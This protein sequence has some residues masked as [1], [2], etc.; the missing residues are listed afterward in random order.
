[1]FFWF[2]HSERPSECE[3][4]VCKCSRGRKYQVDLENNRH[5]LVYCQYCGSHAIHLGC[6]AGEEFLCDECTSIV[7]R[8]RKNAASSLSTGSGREILRGGN[9]NGQNFNEIAR[10]S[11]DRFGKYTSLEKALVAKYNLREF[12]ILLRRLTPRDLGLKIKMKSESDTTDIINTTFTTETTETTDTSDT[13]ARDSDSGGSQTD[14][15]DGNVPIILSSELK[16]LMSELE[17]K[18]EPELKPAKRTRIFARNQFF[19]SDSNSDLDMDAIPKFDINDNSRDIPSSN[20]KVN[21][22]LTEPDG[23]SQQSG[24]TGMRAR[25]LSSSDEEYEIKPN[26]TDI[27]KLLF[28]ESSDDQ[29]FGKENEQPSKNVAVVRPFSMIETSSDENVKPFKSK[30]RSVSFISSSDE[31]LKPSSLSECQITKTKHDITIMNGM[32][33]RSEIVTS[34]TKP[35]PVKR[36]RR[37]V[38]SYLRE[39]SSSDDET[40][41]PKRKRKS[42]KVKSRAP[43]KQE[44]E[45]GQSTIMNYFTKKFNQSQ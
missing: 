38:L 6:A 21:Q 27:R 33:R 22:K 3:A 31:F 23:F 34:S 32:A 16:I 35:S 42:P 15:S 45:R 14:S 30:V 39:T 36:K 20:S 25:Q 18:V 17:K 29:M 26:V 5:S 9:S 2:K 41:E 37:T 12:S 44:L 8:V 40:Y 1:M 7:A 11:E 43:A 13:N 4:K 24:Q 10:N 28:S 19:D